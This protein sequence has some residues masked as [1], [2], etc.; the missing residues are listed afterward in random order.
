MCLMSA[1]LQQMQGGCGIMIS[2]SSQE[3]GW[4]EYQLATIS[5]STSRLHAKNCIAKNS[6]YKEHHLK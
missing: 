2:F 5:N 4:R 6:Q 3:A 1:N